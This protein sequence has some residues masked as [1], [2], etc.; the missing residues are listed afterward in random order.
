LRLIAPYRDKVVVGV[1]GIFPWSWL[2]DL[3]Q[4]AGITF[5]LGPALS[6]KA[7]HGGK[8]KND[9]SDAHQIAVR[10]RGGMFPHA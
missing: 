5:V 1:E 2:A 4:K 3:G 9:K 10:L 7:S 8:A 6:R